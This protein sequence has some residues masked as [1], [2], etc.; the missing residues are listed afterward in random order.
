MVDCSAAASLAWVTLAFGAPALAFSAVVGIRTSQLFE[1]VFLDTE[2][3]TFLAPAI[4]ENPSFCMG[5]SRQ[6]WR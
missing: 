1:L 3:G 2:L 5:N 6:P 4:G